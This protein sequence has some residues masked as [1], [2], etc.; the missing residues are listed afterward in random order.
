MTI[1][2]L[3]FSSGQRSVAIAV[4]GSVLHEA[5]ETGGRGVAAFGM[6]ERVLVDAKLEREQVQGIVV[7][8]GP[9]S[10]TGIRAAIALAEGWR[11]ARDVSVAGV[12]S[13]EAIA[14]VAQSK[15]IFGPVTI[16]VDAQ[17]EE[18]YCA[19]YDITQSSSTETVPLR[20]VSRAETMSLSQ[21]RAIIG[22]EAPKFSSGRL[23]FPGAA[24]LA[25]L[26]GNRKDSTSMKQLEPIYLRETAFV[27]AK[28]P[29]FL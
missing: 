26:A 6:I 13:I 4:N 3:E 25:K 5:I 23:I 12:S 2:A 8:L 28:P 27:K 24:A 22:P 15:G 1:L 9:G 29:G 14:S 20:I 16:V 7:G 18:F 11:Q 19:N 21:G 10:Y 17:R